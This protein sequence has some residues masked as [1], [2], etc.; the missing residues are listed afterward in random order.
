LKREGIKNNCVEH[1]FY[2][3][4]RKT[5]GEFEGT[6]NSRNTSNSGEKEKSR[7]GGGLAEKLKKGE[8]GHP[9]QLNAL[10]PE[11]RAVRVSMNCFLGAELKRFRKFAKGG[12]EA[13]EIG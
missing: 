6:G 4:E 12:R 3:E 8:Q 13:K 9:S 5:R 7:Q 10:R 2:R 11:N 1:G